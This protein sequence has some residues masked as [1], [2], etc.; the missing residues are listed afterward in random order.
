MYVYVRWTLDYV[1]SIISQ[2]VRLQISF[3]QVA[4]KLPSI[5]DSLLEAELH[6]G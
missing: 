6:K 2:L 3:G 1:Q 4:Q 5:L